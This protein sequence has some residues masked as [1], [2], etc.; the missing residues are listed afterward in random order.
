MPAFDAS[1]P[2]RPQPQ[3][4]KIAPGFHRYTM[5]TLGRFWGVGLLLSG[6]LVL[7]G[8][9]GYAP[10]TP[11][12]PGGVRMVLLEPVENLTTVAEADVRLRTRL[13]RQLLNRPDLRL[14]SASHAEAGLRVVLYAAALSRASLE[15][16]LPDTQAVTYT[17]QGR[18][19]LTDRQEGR[20]YLKELP[21][22]GSGQAFYPLTDVETPAHRLE[23]LQRA[24]DALTD[25]VIERLFT[26]L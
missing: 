6:L 19:T 22:S 24:L 8:G 12:M 17:L 18:M 11:R 21:V 15:P 14:V 16:A 7:S 5:R 9:C 23:A 25:Q 13:R 2:T 1:Q 4:P 20:A 26:T 3:G 10:D